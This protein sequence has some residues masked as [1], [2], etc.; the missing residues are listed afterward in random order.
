MTDNFIAKSEIQI[1]A[2]PA[3]VWQA[4]P[5][6]ALV[7]QYLFGTDMV[8]SEWK[9]GGQIRYR[10][11]WTDTAYEDKGEI[12]EIIPGQKLVSTYYSSMSGKPDA[13]ENYSRVSYELSA[14]AGGTKLTITQENN[15]TAQS[16]KH[17]ENNW[18]AVLQSMKQLVEK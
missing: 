10:G 1:N 13:P 11:V 12:L 4:L 18:N 16:A 6:P 14:Q 3:Q 2:Q 8:V 9:V 7:K 17:S 15:P 5:D